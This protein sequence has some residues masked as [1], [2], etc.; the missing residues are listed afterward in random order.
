MRKDGRRA[1]MNEVEHVHGVQSRGAGTRAVGWTIHKDGSAGT[2][3]YQKEN[4]D[5]ARDANCSV[6]A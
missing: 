2:S 3:T 1:S 4:G 5:D 6:G